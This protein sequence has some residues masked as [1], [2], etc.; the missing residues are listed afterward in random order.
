MPEGS[1]T[2]GLIGFISAG[3]LFSHDSLSLSDPSGCGVV[4]AVPSS[5]VMEVKSMSS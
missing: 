2:G 5:E 4:L 3:G 1:A